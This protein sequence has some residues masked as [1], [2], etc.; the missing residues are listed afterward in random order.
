MRSTS[1]TSGVLLLVP[2]FPADEGDSQCLPGVQNYVR[3]LAE[4]G[5]RENRDLAVVPFQYPYRRTPY[6]WEQV[7]VHPLGGRNRSFPARF[8]IWARAV[9][10]VVRLTR[11]GDFSVL[12][13]FWLGE[14]TLLGQW[15]AQGLRLD[16]VA[17]IPGQDARAENPYLPWLAFDRMQVVGGSEFVGRAFEDATG[18]NL[19]RIIPLGLDADRLPTLDPKGA[20]PL[21]VLGVGSL[22]DVKHYSQ[23]I[24][25]IGRLDGCKRDL[26]AE[27]VGGGPNREKLDRLIREKGLAD[28]IRLTGALPREEVLRRMRRARILLHTA[29]YDAQPYVL[30]EALASGMHV[31]STPVGYAGPADR[32]RFSASTEGLANHLRILLQENVSHEPVSVPTAAETAAQYVELYDR[33]P[34]ESDSPAAAPSGES[35]VGS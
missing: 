17:T 16:H 15:L 11:S 33:A 5:R 21:D 20:R 31:V 25:V 30:L 34:T 28:R 9:R 3:A 23:F 19:D 12:H 7:P 2:G 35:A 8:L 27:I 1:S 14:C 26:Q 32:V 6:T 24:E 13:S 22:N 18:R 29:R 10:E 4:Y